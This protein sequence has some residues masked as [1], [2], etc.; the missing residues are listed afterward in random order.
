MMLHVRKKSK[1]RHRYRRP[2]Q[3]HDQKVHAGGKQQNALGARLTR[4][5]KPGQ[6]L[7][8]RKTKRKKSRRRSRRCQ[9]H[10]D[11]KVHAEEKRRKPKATRREVKAN[12]IRK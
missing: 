8:P 11:R 6:K 5:P 3:K 2:P 12:S 4:R 9:R 10:Q 7:E 1:R